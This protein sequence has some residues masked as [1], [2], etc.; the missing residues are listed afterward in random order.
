MAQILFRFSKDLKQICS[1][2]LMSNRTLEC[3]HDLEKLASKRLFFE[4]VLPSIHISG[5]LAF[6]V[7]GE[8]LH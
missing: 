6:S 2:S 4:I 7:V 3:N 8:Q 1:H 5:P